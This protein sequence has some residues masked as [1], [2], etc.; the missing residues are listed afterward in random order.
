[1][2]LPTG[3]VPFVEFKELS[4]QWKWIGMMLSHIFRSLY[5]AV[6]HRLFKCI[7]LHNYITIQKFEVGKLIY[8]IK[9]MQ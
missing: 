3:F 1:M 9:K 8:L 4:Q 5:F 6:L 7:R 2:T